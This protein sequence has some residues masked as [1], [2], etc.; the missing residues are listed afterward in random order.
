MKY[1]LAPNGME[2]HPETLA[3]SLGYDP[4]LSQGS[5]KTP[6]FLTSTFQFAS[7]EE[8]KRFFEL[9]YSLREKQEG[10]EQGLIYSRINNPNLQIFEER[11]AAWDRTELA[12]T[13]CSGMAAIATSMLAL[14]RPGDYV[15]ASAP[16]YGGSH[17]LFEKILPLYGITVIQIPG[18]DSTPAE[19][20]KKALELGPEKV[21]L[22]YI[23]TPANPSNILIDI[24]AIA[25]L[26]KK[27]RE[28]G[29]AKVYTAIDN[30]FLGPVFQQPAQFGVDLIL[31]SATKFIGGHSDLIAGIASGTKE[32]IQPILGFRTIMGT[33]ANPFTGW[34]LLRSLETL[35]IR[36]NRQAKSA[37]KIAELL[38]SHPKVTKVHF[39]GF[40]DETSTQHRIFRNQCKGSGS[41]ISFDIL[42]GEKEAFKVLNAF[43]VCRLAVSLGG[44]ESLVEHPMTMTHSD[45][46][47]ADLEKIGVSASMIRLSVGVEHLSDLT[48]DI[49]QAL[50]VLG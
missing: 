12:A 31:Y 1:S 19:M 23:E 3:L 11:I 4:T 22:L 26:A 48:A 29:K 46:P 10:E 34:M 18:G 14:L 44:T 27:L 16:V 15:L 39:P 13:F 17:Y 24:E 33:M 7:A 47:P 25:Q 21:R 42:G 43:K 2:L 36:M 35:S 40:H 45:V 50:A 5:V 49:L 8:G 32:V 41:L 20:E 30:T 38:N 6:V 28:L 37:R 9:A